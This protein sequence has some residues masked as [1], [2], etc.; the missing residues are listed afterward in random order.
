MLDVIWRLGMTVLIL[1]VLAAFSPGLHLGAA[2]RLIEQVAGQ[3]PQ[4]RIVDYLEAIAQGDVQAALKLWSPAGPDSP[5][6]EARRQAVTAELLRFGPDLAYQVLDVE[7]WRTCCEPGVIEND[8][9]AGGARMRVR[10]WS[11]DLPSKTYVFDVL[12]PGGY[13]GEVTGS[14]LRTWTIFDVYPEG[15]APIVWTW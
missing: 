13:W 12:V 8:R 14:P 2:N 10:I 9:E 1:V 4:A 5:E 11:E 15:Q 7:W 6:L 3:A